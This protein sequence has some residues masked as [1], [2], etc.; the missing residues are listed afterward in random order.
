MFTVTDKE[1]PLAQFG[2]LPSPPAG[3]QI[4]EVIIKNE[5]HEGFF[6]KMK[7]RY[8]WYPLHDIDFIGKMTQQPMSFGILY[9]CRI[10]WTQ[11]IA[12][13]ALDN[14]P[15]SLDQ[16]G[17]EEAPLKTFVMTPFGQCVYLH[18]NYAERGMRIF[19]HLKGAQPEVVAAI[20]QIILPDVPTNLLSLGKYL[21]EEAP[22]NIEIA[23]LDP[24]T[25]HLA[26]QT[27]AS[28]LEGVN[29]AVSY[30]R[31]L[32][33]ESEGEILTRRNKGVGKAHLDP[34][35]RYAYHMTGRA[36]PLEATLENSPEKRTTE[37][38]ERLVEAVTSRNGA[39]P[40]AQSSDDD[41]A[42][43][44]AELR[45]MQNKFNELLVLAQNNKANDDGAPTV[46]DETVVNTET[47]Q[48]VLKT[49]LKKLK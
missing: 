22:K 32:I 43:L 25:R 39:Q 3:S 15:D 14:S 23:D 33:E 13:K 7:D 5:D 10:G 18:S 6:D 9:R 44:R 47:A 17:E 26:L 12:Y 38:L 35:D 42:A 29:T 49:K 4:K 21:A 2:Q 20:E 34:N 19:E 8:A 1:N 16:L 28:M 11:S 36:I 27:L 46:E 45:E 31:K 30:C 48:E 40:V 37:L 24:K 41:V